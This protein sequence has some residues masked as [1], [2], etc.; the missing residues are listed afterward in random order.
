M[1]KLSV[2]LTIVAVLLLS[3]LAYGQGYYG[4]MYDQD[5]FEA[6]RLHAGWYDV[7]DAG[8]DLGFGADRISRD[9]L[10]SFDYVSTNKGSTDIDIMSVAAS[11]L[12]RMADNPATYYGAGVG[13]YDVDADGFGDSDL[14]YH[15]V[16]GTEL[17]SPDEF[18]EAAWFAEAKYVFG[19][20]LTFSDIDGVRLVVGRRF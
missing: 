16:V 6:W 1:H 14:G 20:K 9:Y 19:T 17:G 15:A 10:V 3:G 11:Y 12:W 13:W 18:G 5:A 2:A 7:G 8:S 4:Q